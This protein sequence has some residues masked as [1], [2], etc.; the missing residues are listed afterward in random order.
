MLVRM[1]TIW[2]EE[3]SGFSNE[4]KKKK[5]AYLPDSNAGEAIGEISVVILKIPSNFLSPNGCVTSADICATTLP[6][7]ELSHSTQIQIYLVGPSLTSAM[8][9]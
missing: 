6:K 2:S 4:N 8:P 9:G 7:D 5:K 1:G 3:L